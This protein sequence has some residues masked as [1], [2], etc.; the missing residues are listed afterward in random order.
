MGGTES[1]SAARRRCSGRDSGHDH[2][3]FPLLPGSLAAPERETVVADSH[4]GLGGLGTLGPPVGGSAGSP[5]AGPGGHHP[6]QTPPPAHVVRWG[7]RPA[8]SR[9]SATDDCRLVRG[10]GSVIAAVC[11]YCPARCVYFFA[12]WRSR[13]LQQTS[14]MW[15]PSISS[16]LTHPPTTNGVRLLGLQRPTTGVRLIELHESIGL[17]DRDLR[18]SSVSVEDM[19]YVALGDLFARQVS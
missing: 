17:L 18:Q 6:A 13:Y 12:V 4:H 5:R 16:V 2:D 14:V 19:K 11:D 7:R 9:A 3:G 10:G 15:A 8:N 1:D